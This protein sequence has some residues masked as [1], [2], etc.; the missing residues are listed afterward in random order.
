MHSKDHLILNSRVLLS[1][2]SPWTPISFADG[3]VRKSLIQ[4]WGIKDQACFTW[5]RCLQRSE[6]VDC[7]RFPIMIQ[8]WQRN[9][10][11]IFFSFYRWGIKLVS[12]QR[13]KTVT[14]LLNT[15][16]RT[17]YRLMTICSHVYMNKSSS[18][19]SWD[20]YGHRNGFQSGIRQYLKASQRKLKHLLLV[21]KG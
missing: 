21:P 16:L 17:F 10:I 3:R 13:M 20:S 2:L 11:K 1:I 12:R 18:P 5:Q 6:E 14:S 9:V 4:R 19:P 8:L 7:F 15:N